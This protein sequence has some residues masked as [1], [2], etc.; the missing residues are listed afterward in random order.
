MRHVTHVRRRI[1]PHAEPFRE[2]P[3]L[4]M[5]R[6]GKLSRVHVR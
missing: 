1:P 2:S 5:R 6:W 4:A 3:Q